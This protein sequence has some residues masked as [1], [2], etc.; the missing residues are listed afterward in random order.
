MSAQMLNF[1]NLNFSCS[2]IFIVYYVINVS[3]R[4]KQT[5]NLKFLQE[6]SQI[7]CIQNM[8]LNFVF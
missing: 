5:S 2:R 7:Y 3:G 1:R 6:D 8:S 4:V